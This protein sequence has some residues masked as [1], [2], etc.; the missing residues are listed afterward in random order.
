MLTN[1]ATALRRGRMQATKA[2]NASKGSTA[3]PGYR[4][5]SSS[6]PHIQRPTAVST[7]ETSTGTSQANSSTA[8]N[9]Q[10]WVRQCLLRPNQAQ[11]WP[12][13]GSPCKRSSCSTPSNASASTPPPER[14]WTCGSPTACKPKSAPPPSRGAV[15]TPTAA[16]STHRGHAPR[17]PAMALLPS[18]GPTSIVAQNARAALSQEP[19][20]DP[21]WATAWPSRT[22]WTKSTQATQSM[23]TACTSSTNSNVAKKPQK[24]RSQLCTKPTGAKPSNCQRRHGRSP[25]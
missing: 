10:A 5:A 15:T 13:G 20:S 9:L 4:Q 11:S 8:S 7:L 17:S 22:L 21:P 24:K 14:G 23:R 6:R 1:S 25:A 19:T 2:P 12:E 16:A 3:T 18:T